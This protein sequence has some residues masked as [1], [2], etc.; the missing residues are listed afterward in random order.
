MKLVLM[1]EG[2]D[3]FKNISIKGVQLREEMKETN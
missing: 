3:E 1:I 2:I